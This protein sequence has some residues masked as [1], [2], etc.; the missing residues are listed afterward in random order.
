MKLPVT[1]Y[2]GS[3]RKLID[4]IWEALEVNHIEFNSVLDLFGGTGIVSY[5]M[6]HKGKKVIYNDIL[7]F[8]CQIAKA[9]LQSPRGIFTEKEA[10]T[11][12]QKRDDHQYQHYVS[13]YFRDIYYLDEENELIDTV[14]QNIPLLPMEKQSSAYY[15][16]FQSCMIKRPFNIFHRKNLNLRTNFTEAKFG[17]KVTWEQKFEDLFAQFAKELNTFQFEQLPQ[18]DIINTS[19]LNCRQHADLVY[20]DTPYFTKDSGSSI[21]YHNRYH[22]LEGLMHYEHIPELIDKHKVNKELSSGKCSEFETRSLFKK[23]LDTLIALHQDSV[24]ALSYTTEGYPPVEDIEAIIH[25]YKP[26]IQ[27]CY[28][29]KHGFALN[30]NNADRQEILIIGTDTTHTPDTTPY[31]I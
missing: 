26:T 28:L 29:G 27:R 4:K 15:L 13:D 8:N 22:F 21:T 20:I 24:I 2:Y 16:L 10:L 19:A 30:R 14:I 9:L 17:N 6:A 11:L 12:L 25:R 18:C 23:N 7:S 5:Y 3:K 1:R 31:V